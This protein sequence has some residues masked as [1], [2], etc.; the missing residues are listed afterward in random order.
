MKDEELATTYDH[1]V[2]KITTALVTPLYEKE[3]NGKDI[4][5]MTIQGEHSF[6]A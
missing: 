5:A 1:D 6:D 3:S 2:F 4:C